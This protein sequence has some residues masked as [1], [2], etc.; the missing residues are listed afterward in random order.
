MPPC[1]G[2]KE[3]A[4]VITWEGHTVRWGRLTPYY[5]ECRSSK[6]GGGLTLQFDTEE[7]CQ[8]AYDVLTDSSAGRSKPFYV[9]RGAFGC[10]MRGDMK[11]HEA[12]TI[13]DD[14]HILHIESIGNSTLGKI[15]GALLSLFNEGLPR[16]A[17]HWMKEADA[18]H[19]P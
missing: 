19:S 9:N 17:L 6:Q 11:A 14:P 5:G 12:L 2:E 10:V 4:K 8:Q 16:V 7:H 13:G 3:L 1:N 15:H 18:R